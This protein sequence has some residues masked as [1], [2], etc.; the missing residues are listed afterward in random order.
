[1]AEPTT[2]QRIGRYEVKI[3]RAQK[4]L[5]PQDDITKGELIDY[6]HRVARWMLPYLKDRALAME[7][8]PDGIE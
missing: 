3:T 5:F 1:V 2:I 6:Y 8:Y 4:V 7:R